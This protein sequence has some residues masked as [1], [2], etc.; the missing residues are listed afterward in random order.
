[1]LG[2]YGHSEIY[3]QSSPSDTFHLRSP[4]YFFIHPYHVA[5]VKSGDWFYIFHDSQLLFRQKASVLPMSGNGQIRIGTWP[6]GD[7]ST[8]RYFFKERLLEL[9]VSNVARYAPPITRV[10]GL[11]A[12][13][14]FEEGSGNTIIDGSGNG[15]N[16]TITRA[17]RTDGIRGS[18]LTFLDSSYAEIGCH[19]QFNIDSAL[20][21]I[22]WIRPYHLANRRTILDRQFVSRG[23]LIGIYDGKLTAYGDSKL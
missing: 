8:N 15:H 17:V 20:T 16:G 21:I 12:S 11:V 10:N 7:T 2:G 5:M 14:S 22:T 3:I 4:E 13:W 19:S 18:S 1:M 23:Y 9:H 6:G